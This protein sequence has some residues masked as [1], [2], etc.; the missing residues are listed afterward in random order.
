MY[1]INEK[2]SV[3][4]DVTMITADIS[5]KDVAVVAK[6]IEKISQTDIKTE[7]LDYHKIRDNSSLTFLVE[8]SG[9]L[10]IAGVLG[11]FKQKSDILCNVYPQNSAV[12]V[13]NFK[14]PAENAATVLKTLAEAK[15]DVYHLF[16][17]MNSLTVV[18]N[19]AYTDRACAVLEKIF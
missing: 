14:N 7:F 10:R 19:E 9:I 16:C 6:I 2:L 5:S 4:D 3:R 13:E 1:K 11:R 15:I 12:T 8:N 18:I 17:G